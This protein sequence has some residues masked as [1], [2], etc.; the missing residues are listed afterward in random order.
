MEQEYVA[1]KN[2]KKTIIEGTK[3]PVGN[4]S[5]VDTA[6]STEFVAS[7]IWSNFQN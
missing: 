1:P 4:H 6:P 2:N 7:R 3:K 5:T